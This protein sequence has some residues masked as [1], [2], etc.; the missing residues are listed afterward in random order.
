MEVTIGKGEIWTM[1][2]INTLRTGMMDSIAMPRT[3]EVTGAPEVEEVEAA[4]EDL[5]KTDQSR[6]RNNHS[7]CQLIGGQELGTW[8]LFGMLRRL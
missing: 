1:R 4:P 8:I 7:P 6:C 3:V 2:G 5:D